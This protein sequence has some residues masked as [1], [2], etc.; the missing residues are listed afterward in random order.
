MA[1]EYV[2]QI[3][4]RLEEDFVRQ[5]LDGSQNQDRGT[6]CLEHF[7]QNS[8]H[9]RKATVYLVNSPTGENQNVMVCFVEP[10]DFKVIGL[11]VVSLQSLEFRP[12]EKESGLASPI[13]LKPVNQGG[14]SRATRLGGIQDF[15]IAR[16]QDGASQLKLEVD[17]YARLEVLASVLDS[18]RAESSSVFLHGFNDPH[19]YPYRSIHLFC[20]PD[21]KALAKVILRKL[22]LKSVQQKAE[23]LENL[24]S[25]EW[26]CIDWE[27]A[28]TEL[29]TVTQGSVEQAQQAEDEDEVK[30]DGDWILLKT[31]VKGSQDADRAIAA[32]QSRFQHSSNQWKTL[33]YQHE[34]RASSVQLS[35]VEGDIRAAIF[36]IVLPETMEDGS[37]VTDEE[38][39]FSLR[40]A[41][42]YDDVALLDWL[43]DNSAMT[44]NM[45]KQTDDEGF[46]VIQQA[47]RVGSLNVVRNLISRQYT[48][49]DVFSLLRHQTT[50]SGETALHLA[51]RCGYP[52]I[53]HEVLQAVD[54]SKR[55][56]LIS[57]QDKQNQSIEDIAG[58]IHKDYGLLA[59]AV[60]KCESL[61]VHSGLID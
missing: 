34:H 18:E 8:P 53:L 13:I 59:G 24:K 14:S 16:D 37:T 12:I 19:R 39:A 43:I 4:Q 41:A 45:L 29:S 46:T 32:L 47:C 20:Q 57:L 23:F 35:V 49:D 6:K 42:M 40:E 28:I 58:Q 21:S 25:I 61:V 36:I 55:Q 48:S 22:A 31:T 7:I 33:T 11:P 10:V 3:K 44:M 1:E 15:I 5:Q 51:V 9:Y 26:S 56:E 38:L 27:R 54:R 30:N 50:E 52:Q 17:D 60:I 2:D